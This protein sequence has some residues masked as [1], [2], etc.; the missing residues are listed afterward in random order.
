MGLGVL[1][2]PLGSR[3]TRYWGLD[4]IGLLLVPRQWST[5]WNAY[6]KCVLFCCITGDL[7][8][9]NS[10]DRSSVENEEGAIVLCREVSR[11][12]EPIVTV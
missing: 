4:E 5:S 6:C 10:Q 3:S 7:G 2:I 8:C 12:E 11:Q 1:D 9:I